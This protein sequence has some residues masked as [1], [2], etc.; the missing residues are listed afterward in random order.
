MICVYV[1][2]FLLQQKNVFYTINDV[3]IKKNEK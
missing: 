3:L 1:I 2:F